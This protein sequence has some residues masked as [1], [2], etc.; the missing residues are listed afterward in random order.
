MFEYGGWIE[1]KIHVIHLN[2]EKY[3]VIFIK[4]QK[5]TLII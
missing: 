2:Q 4:D 5:F 1:K 3:N